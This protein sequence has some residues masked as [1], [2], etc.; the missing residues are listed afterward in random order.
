MSKKSARGFGKKPSTDL[1]Q[2]EQFVLEVSSILAHEVA[3]EKL[4]E[5]DPSKTQ[6][7]WKD[8]LIRAVALRFAEEISSPSSELDA[9]IEK[10]R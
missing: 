5:L 4:A 8:W 6:P 10:F 3:A 1:D 2:E 9:L 7:E